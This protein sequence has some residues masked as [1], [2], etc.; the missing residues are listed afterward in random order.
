MRIN[1]RGWELSARQIRT[2]LAVVDF[3]GVS[4]AAEQLHVT[5]PAVSKM[6]RGIEQI[7]DA[8]LFEKQGRQLVLTRAG[9]MFLRHARG[10][11]AELTSGMMELDA[12]HENQTELVRV[13]T[14]QSLQPVCIP[15]VITRLMARR[16][17]VQVVMS[18][19]AYFGIADILPAV[20]RG[21]VDLGITVFQEDLGQGILTGRE[22]FGARLEVVARRDHSLAGRERVA[23]AEIMDEVVVLPPLESLAGRIL[24]QE[25]SAAGLQFPRRRII[26]ASR[27]L[28]LGLVRASNAVA[29][30]TSHPVCVNENDRDLVRLPIAFRQPIPWKISLC[31]RAASVRSPALGEFIECLEELVREAEER[32]PLPSWQSQIL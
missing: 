19:E 18:G 5:Q 27:E 30:S 20:A 29:F 17:A 10:I 14:A 25:F 32:E 7:L 28:S 3:G 8:N 23:I 9:Q 12:L 13:A 6:I 26:A 1:V 24:V 11:M 31:E 15:E 22:L 21:D 4:P 2:F 16:P